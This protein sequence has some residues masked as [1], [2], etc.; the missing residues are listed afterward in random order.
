MYVR[1]RNPQ[2]PR[3]IATLN[4]T[5]SPNPSARAR[6]RR[7]ARPLWARRVSASAPTRTSP[8][9]ASVT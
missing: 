3:A 2:L 5:T 9:Q 6:S 8:A 4:A 7:V 1:V